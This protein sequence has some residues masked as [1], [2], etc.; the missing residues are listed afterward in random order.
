VTKTGK[1]N[2]SA[3][4]R[5]LVRQG[6][7]VLALAPM[8]ASGRM[9]R[10]AGQR[11]TAAATSLGTMGLEKMTTFAQAWTAMASAGMQA[12]LKFAMSMW[13]PKT[14][15]SARARAGGVRSGHDG[16]A[17]ADA[18]VSMASSAMKPVR[19]RVKRN[20]GKRKRA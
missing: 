8:V 2:Q 14:S 3:A 1:R 7:N 19:A 5:R 6:A 10:L 15:G 18:L 9:M 12:Q 13:V 16:F 20:A 11:P 4:M 17:L